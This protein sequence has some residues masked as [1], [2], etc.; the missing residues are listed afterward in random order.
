MKANNPSRL[1]KPCDVWKRLNISER[2]LRTLTKK[3]DIPCVRLSERTVRYRPTDI[4]RIV[5]G[6]TGGSSDDSQVD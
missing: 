6:E 4:E 5:S 3:G 1:L 2:T